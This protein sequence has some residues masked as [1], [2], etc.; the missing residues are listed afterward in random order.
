MKRLW[1]IASFAAM[2]VVLSGCVVLIEVRTPLLY[3]ASVR[4]DFQD[5]ETFYICDTRDTL[6]TYSFR[7]SSALVSWRSYLLGVDTG[8]IRYERTLTFSSPRVTVDRDRV[9]YRFIIER[10]TAPLSV[11][12]PAV[13]PQG[14]DVE[15]G[16]ARLVLVGSG[17]DGAT[18]ELE[19]APIS[20]RLATGATCPAD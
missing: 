4:T 14:I 11:D 5:G 2:V 10:G 9:T 13:A 20:I 19:S 8:Q 16:K 1:L 18:L 12:T 7:F 6:M 17:S 15:V 3:A